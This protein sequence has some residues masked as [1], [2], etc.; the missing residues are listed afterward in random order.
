MRHFK[1]NGLQSQGDGSPR[2]GHPR[3]MP[4]QARQ[5]QPS[6]LPL[7]AIAYRDLANDAAVHCGAR[8][9]VSKLP[10]A[11]YSKNKFD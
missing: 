6:R 7:R 5:G 1:P 9:A 10:G 4:Q 11:G 3:G 8:P 2:Y